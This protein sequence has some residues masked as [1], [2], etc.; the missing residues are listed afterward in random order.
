MLHLRFAETKDVQRIFDIFDYYAHNSHYTMETQSPPCSVYTEMIE[1]DGDQYPFLVLCDDDT[2]VG[3]TY[4]KPFG[5]RDAYKWNV[6]IS[7]FIQKEYTHCGA[8]KIITVAIIELLKSL[9]FQ[10][11]YVGVVLP[12]EKGGENLLTSMGFRTTRIMHKRGYKFNKWYDI[13]QMELPFGDH[14]ETVPPLKRISELDSDYL[15]Q[16]FGETNRKLEQLSRTDNE[17]K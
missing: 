17:V 2:V 9:G 8:G 3:Y 14:P 7:A 13:L 10:N 4:V 16:L 12:K 5:V 15:S 11:A 1:Q 6:E